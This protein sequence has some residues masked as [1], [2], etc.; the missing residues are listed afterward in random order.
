MNQNRYF[1][2]FLTLAIDIENATTIEDIDDMVFWVDECREF[3][4]EY[5][6][7]SLRTMIRFKDRCIKD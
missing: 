5:L 1:T 7:Q 6:Y 3:I 2:T 4:P